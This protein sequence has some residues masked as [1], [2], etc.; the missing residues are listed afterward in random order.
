VEDG[1]LLLEASLVLDDD[2]EGRKVTKRNTH[3][4][5]RWEGRR[6]KVEQRKKKERKHTSIG[7]IGLI[8]YYYG[9]TT[10]KVAHRAVN[11]SLYIGPQRRLYKA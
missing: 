10:R 5:W 4:G 3:S 9:I 6:R 7:I 1:R 8:D 11:V 2:V